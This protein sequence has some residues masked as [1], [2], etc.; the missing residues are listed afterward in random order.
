MNEK[1]LIKEVIKEMFESGE[2]QI[3]AK[4]DWIFKDITIKVN[5][6]GETIIENH[7][8]TAPCGS[9]KSCVGCGTLNSC[10]HKG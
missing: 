7:S 2:I 5:I 3:T 6:K 10:S 9:H 8:L 1:L 4:Q